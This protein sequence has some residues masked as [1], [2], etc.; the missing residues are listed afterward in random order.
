[1]LRH[2]TNQIALV[3]ELLIAGWTIVSLLFGRGWHVI[4]IVI[5]VFMA[6]QQLLLSEGLVT[7]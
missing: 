3:S 1:M 7:V 4:W 2:M 6:L 5:Q